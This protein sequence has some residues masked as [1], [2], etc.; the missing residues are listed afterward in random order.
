MVT[1]YTEKAA[2]HVYTRR[3]FLADHDNLYNVFIMKDVPRSERGSR[4]ASNTLNEAANSNKLGTAQTNSATESSDSSAAIHSAQDTNTNS[5]TI[6]NLDIE[7]ATENS[8]DGG[9][10]TDQDIQDFA[11]VVDS[12]EI[13]ANR[14]GANTEEEGGNLTLG[15]TGN[16]II[17][18]QPNTGMVTRGGAA[19]LGN[20]EVETR[21]TGS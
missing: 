4:R 18:Q 3:Y 8:T 9:V 11:E 7:S 2:E 20:G 5:E 14:R 15:N 19:R 21:E 1:F 16:E 6:E 17:G 10:P 13:L 12:M